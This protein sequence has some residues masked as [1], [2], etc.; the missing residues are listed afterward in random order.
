MIINIVF[1]YYLKLEGVISKNQ[2]TEFSSSSLRE[3]SKEDLI[4]FFCFRGKHNKEVLIF[5]KM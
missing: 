1:Y 4:E 3:L 5:P 2:I